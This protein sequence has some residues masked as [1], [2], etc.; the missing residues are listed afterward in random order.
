MNHLVRQYYFQFNHLCSITH[1]RWENGDRERNF[2]S[3]TFVPLP[4]KTSIRRTNTKN[5]NSTTFVLLPFEASIFSSEGAYFNSTTFVLLRIFS[6]TCA[7]YQL[8]FN[9][10]TF[11]LLRGL[12][13]GVTTW[14][15]SFQFNH[16]CSITDLTIIEKDRVY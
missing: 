14:T 15:D 2:N 3:T 10:T 5:F 6:R 4:L 16:L 8:Y 9:S 12:G 7:Q 1:N 13:N 11:V